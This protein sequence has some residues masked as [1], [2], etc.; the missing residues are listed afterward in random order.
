MSLAD[1]GG[2]E[3]R[4]PGRAVYPIKFLLKHYPVRSQAHG[5]RK[6]LRE[7]VPR[8]DPA[9]RA[10]GWHTHY[11]HVGPAHRF[12]RA[13]E[14]LEYFDPQRFEA[15]YLI[16]R[17]SGIGLAPEEPRASRPDVLP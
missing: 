1:S 7:R 11:D 12:V 13:P 9:E 4:F 6:V 14:T 16:E 5:L 15:N 2:H 17:L 8:W 10:A 3:V